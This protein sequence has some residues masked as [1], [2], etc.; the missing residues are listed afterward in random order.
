MRAGGPTDKI[1]ANQY[2]NV[3]RGNR[4]LAELAFMRFEALRN[5]PHLLPGSHI[6][7]PTPHT[8]TRR[9]SQGRNS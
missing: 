3:T 7:A 6:L 1:H 4:R 2:A 8:P 5:L 9:H